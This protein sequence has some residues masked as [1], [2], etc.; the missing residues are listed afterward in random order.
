MASCRRTFHQRQVFVDDPGRGAPSDQEGRSCYDCDADHD[1]I[2]FTLKGL[3]PLCFNWSRI[4]RHNL[5]RALVLG[6]LPRD[7]LSGVPN[8]LRFS[9]QITIW[10]VEVE[11]VRLTLRGGRVPCAHNA[12]ADGRAL[13]PPSVCNTTPCKKAGEKSLALITVYE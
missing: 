7:S 10:L 2:S 12:S 5:S 9:P 1:P 8:S 3:L 11:E 6:D 4:V 13:F